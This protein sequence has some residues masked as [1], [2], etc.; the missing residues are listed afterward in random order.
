M[1]ALSWNRLEPLPMVGLVRTTDVVAWNCRSKSYL[2]Y[3]PTSF[4]SDGAS[5]PS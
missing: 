1:D 2:V 3:L 5:V 4:Y